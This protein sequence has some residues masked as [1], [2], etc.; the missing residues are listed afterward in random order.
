M[1]EEREGVPLIYNERHNGKSAGEDGQEYT[2]RAS[3]FAHG[4]TNYCSGDISG[5]TNLHNVRLLHLKYKKHSKW[6]EWT[7]TLGDGA[8]RLYRHDCKEP[9]RFQL[10]EEIRADGNRLI[11]EYE[12]WRVPKRN[13]IKT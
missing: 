6:G 10:A 3:A 5:A 13:R 2:L 7:V 12:D 4:Y 1:M 11:Y 9:Y 8:Q